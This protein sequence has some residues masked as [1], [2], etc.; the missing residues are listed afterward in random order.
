MRLLLIR[1]AVTGET[2][3]TLTGRLPGVALSEAGRRMASSL[4]DELSDLP[5]RRVYTSP[6]LRCKQTAAPLAATWNVA[7]V[8]DRGFIETDFGTWSGRSLASLR[9]L[10]AWQGLFVAPSRFRF[11]QGESLG[12]VQARAVAATESL[13]DRHARET[14]AVV[15]H[16]DVIRTV[17][18][19]YLGTPLDL[20]QRIDIAPASVSIVDLPLRGFPRVP[21][22]N[23]VLDVGRWR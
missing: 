23:A 8:V 14:V 1:H 18:A 21:V 2:G 20:F 11:P 9:R 17:V 22:V 7:P 16:S 6:I 12:E 13:A 3:S 5:V 4:A 19:H 10:K 15:S